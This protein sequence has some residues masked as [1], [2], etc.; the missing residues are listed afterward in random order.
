VNTG[1]HC[2]KLYHSF[3]YILHREAFIYLHYEKQNESKK[4]R[5]LHS[6]FD[7]VVLKDEVYEEQFEKYFKTHYKGKPTKRYK[8]ILDKV[9][10][11]NNFPVGTIERLLMM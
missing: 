4:T 8:R 5:Y 3:K 7:N 2:R 11:A 1:K 10:R 9:E 6:V